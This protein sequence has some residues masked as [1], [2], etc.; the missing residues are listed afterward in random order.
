[1]FQTTIQAWHEFYMLAGGAAATLVGL[2][3]VGLSLHLRVVVSRPEVRS[4]ASVT[5]ANFALVLLIALFGLIP[6]QPQGFGYAVILSG[7]ATGA[8]VAPSLWA[9]SRSQTRTLRV[10][11]LFLRF[12]ISALACAG[13]VAAGVL[14]LRGS[15]G[16]ALGWLAA[17]SVTLN[18]TSLRNSWDLL[19]TVGEARMHEA[20][21][22]DAEHEPDADRARTV[23]AKSAVANRP[24][25]R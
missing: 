11:R 17:V 18:V 6:E 16:T 23:S 3:F 4:L 2:L 5:L 25:E 14:V 15:Y 9:A 7:A 10:R 8:I 12:G 24:A 19:V 1:M 22:L 21:D 13:A 20:R